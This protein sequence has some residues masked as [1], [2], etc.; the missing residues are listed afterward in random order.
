MSPRPIIL[1]SSLLFLP[2]CDFI[3]DL[4]KDWKTKG[5]AQGVAR[6]IARNEGLRNVNLDPRIPC[7]REHS[8]EIT[9]SSISRS[10]GGF[11]CSTSRN[12]SL[13][14]VNLSNDGGSEN[15]ISSLSIGVRLSRTGE[16]TRS[17]LV[18]T[19][20]TPG[21]SM[22]VNFAL[23]REFSCDEVRAAPG[24]NWSWHFVRV[25]GVAVRAQ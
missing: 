17:N 2:G 9:T 3:S 21:Q 19:W 18:E 23:P 14:S 5:T 22:T 24:E 11:I 10:T 8:K 4:Y 15:V 25:D 13:F 16:I 6:C 7:A 12:S 1:L 20:I